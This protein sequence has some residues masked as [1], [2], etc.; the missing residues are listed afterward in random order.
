MK[1][2]NG[3]NQMYG[4]FTFWCMSDGEFNP[5]K[6]IQEFCE[7]QLKPIIDKYKIDK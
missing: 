4:M 2:I 7:I 5:E 3:V 6:M 1:G